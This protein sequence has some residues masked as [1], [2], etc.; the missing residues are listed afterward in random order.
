MSRWQMAI[1][2]ELRL[3][4]KLRARRRFV[5]AV[6]GEHVRLAVRAQQRDCDGDVDFLHRTQ[7]RALRAIEQSERIVRDGDGRVATRD[8]HAVEVSDERIIVAHTQPQ[9]IPRGH[10]RE[11]KRHAQHRG[12]R[13]AEHRAADLLLDDRHEDIEPIGRSRAARECLDLRRR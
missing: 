9:F 8:F 6:D 11:R 3:D 13:D 2:D 10:T 1:R 4:E 5:D 7:H 12:W